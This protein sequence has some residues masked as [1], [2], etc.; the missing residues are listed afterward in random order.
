MLHPFPDPCIIEWKQTDCIILGDAQGEA[1]V[2]LWEGRATGG[3]RTAG[4]KAPGI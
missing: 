1:A 3:T 2:D 4:V